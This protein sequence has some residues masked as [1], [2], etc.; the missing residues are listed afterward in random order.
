ME[1][2]TN[3]EIGYYS[4]AATLSAL[5]IGASDTLKNALTWLMLVL[6]EN[7]GNSIK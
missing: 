7:P 5:Y 4:V 1:S 2:E 3:S 6:A